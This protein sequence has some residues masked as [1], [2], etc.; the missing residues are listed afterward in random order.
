MK[1]FLVHRF[2]WNQH[3]GTAHLFSDPVPEEEAER[4]AEQWRAL[5]LAGVRRLYRGRMYPRH[6]IVK[7][8]EVEVTPYKPPRT[9]DDG[10]RR[11]V[12]VNGVRYE[13]ESAPQEDGRPVVTVFRD[14]R[15]VYRY[16]GD[17]H[18]RTPSGVRSIIREIK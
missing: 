13:W 17:P 10:R 7:V 4:L 8:G 3:G 14:G 18:D 16:T 1:L 6:K 2:D 9:Y 11:R 12:T 15:A 5:D